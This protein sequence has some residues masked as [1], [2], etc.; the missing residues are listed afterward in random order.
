MAKQHVR[1]FVRVFR[2]SVTPQILSAVL[3]RLATAKS[4]EL[5]QT[6]V[7]VFARLVHLNVNKTLDFLSSSALPD[8]SPAL[9]FVMRKWVDSQVDFSGTYQRKVTI[10]AL[11]ALVQ[12]NNPKLNAISVRGTMLWICA[13]ASECSLSVCRGGVTHHRPLDALQGRS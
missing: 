9:P 4:Q 1:V 12:L 8:G 11:A 6:L 5:V 10:L 13:C 7:L 3:A 2:G